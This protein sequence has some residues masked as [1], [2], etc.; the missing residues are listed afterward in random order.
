MEKKL[1]GCG[2]KFS[3]KHDTLCGEWFGGDQ[4]FCDKCFEKIYGKNMEKC[5]QK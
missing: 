5:K 2:K 1:K 3:K 4:H